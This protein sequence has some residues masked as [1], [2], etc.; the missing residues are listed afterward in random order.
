MYSS[1][2]IAVTA[3]AL[4]FVE[5]SSRVY[6]IGIAHAFGTVPPLPLT[7]TEQLM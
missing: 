2:A 4:V 3:V 7:Q 6:Y 1:V 5:G